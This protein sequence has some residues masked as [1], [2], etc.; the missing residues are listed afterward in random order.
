[1]P[2]KA[3]SLLGERPVGACPEAASLMVGE[4]VQ[5]HSLG[6][7]HAFID[8][9][10]SAGGDAPKFQTHIATADTTLAELWRQKFSG[11]GESRHAYWRRVELSEE[12]WAGL[13]RH[14]AEGGVGV[15]DGSAGCTPLADKP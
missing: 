8:A 7:D 1:M 9:M 6:L 14:A 10:P 11:R 4:V 5:D 13:C 15:Y 2:L 3:R 12:R